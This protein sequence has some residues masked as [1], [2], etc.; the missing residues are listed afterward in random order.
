MAR[1]LAA[2]D[3]SACAPFEFARLPFAALIGFL[4][5]GEI[6]DLWTWVGAAIIAGSAVYVAH[7]EALLARRVRRGEPRAPALSRAKKLAETLAITATVAAGPFR[8]RFRRSRA[9]GGCRGR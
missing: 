4:W 1:A 7:R 3:A 5:F 8:V 9:Q 6:T 2:A